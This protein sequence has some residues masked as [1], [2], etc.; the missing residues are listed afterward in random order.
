MK[1]RQD[2]I[3]ATLELLN[4]LAAGQAPDPED[5]LTIDGLIDGKI[6]ELNRQDIIYFTDTQNF[7]DEYVDPLATILAD[8]AAPSFG[9]PRNPESRADAIARL[10]AMK[11]STYVSGTPLQV[12]YF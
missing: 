10:Q 5:A 8:M 7:E 11:P 6:A 1:T 3:A 4:V 12:D 9:Q 2:L